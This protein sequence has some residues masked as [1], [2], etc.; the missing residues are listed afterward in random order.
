MKAKTT[1]SI[2]IAVSFLCFNIC[3]QTG[4]GEYKKINLKKK[5]DQ[6]GTRGSS[7]PL[8]GLDITEAEKQLEIG[9]Y[10]ALIV[11][12]DNYSGVWKPLEN[13]VRDAKTVEN[14]L[15]ANYNFDQFRALYNEEATRE[16]IHQAMSWLMENTTEKDNVLIYFSGH[17]DYKQQ[18]NKGFWV[19]VDAQTQMVGELISNN[20]IQSYLTGI[21]AK[22]TL[23]ISDAC[24]SGD[25]FRGD[26]ISVAFEESDRYYR[27]VNSLISRK[28][29]TSGGIEP[30]M[31]GGKDGHSIFAYYFLKALNN[32]GKKYYDASELFNDIKIPVTNNSDQR[33]RF[34]P[35]SNTGDEGGQFIFIRK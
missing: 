25:I 20:D 14:T 26:V 9:N 19:P 4:E 10:Y 7:D 3:A 8:K 11:G 31:D 2:V 33:P 24:F 22:H 23:L 18:M 1:I 16:N 15:N 29:L 32:N 5:S 12:V 21:P 17:G 6:S 28:A 13:A 30:V 27:E 35:I 34:E